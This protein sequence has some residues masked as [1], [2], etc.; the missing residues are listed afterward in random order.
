MAQTSYPHPAVEHAAIHL[1]V[2]RYRRAGL[3]WG[4]APQ[5]STASTS[6]CS[7]LSERAERILR[8]AALYL[9]EVA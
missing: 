3:V 2:C 8:S 7:E 6:T 1:A 9:V 4:A 5:I